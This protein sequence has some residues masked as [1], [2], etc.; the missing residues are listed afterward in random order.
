[1]SNGLSSFLNMRVEKGVLVS[2]KASRCEA[3]MSSYYLASVEVT[4]QLSFSGTVTE[5]YPL[6]LSLYYLQRVSIFLVFVSSAVK[7][8]SISWTAS[9]VK[10]GINWYMECNCIHCI[11]FLGNKVYTSTYS[12]ANPWKTC[13]WLHLLCY[14]PVVAGDTLNSIFVL[15]C[16]FTCAGSFLYSRAIICMG[17]LIWL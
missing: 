4:L 1:M 17:E 5:L 2:C 3:F 14:T 11:T 8:S 9:E 6:C 12:D 13:S 16:L 15:C 7:F 10:G